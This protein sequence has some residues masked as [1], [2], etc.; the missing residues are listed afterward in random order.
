MVT[1]KYL[2]DTD[3]IVFYLRGREPYVSTLK[4]LQKEGLAVSVISVAELYEGVFRGQNPQTRE[5]GL[6]RFLAGVVV[7]DVNK[8]VA[9]VF[10]QLRAE[11]RQQGLTVADLDLLIGSTA[12]HYGLLL[13]TDN[14]RHYEKIPGLRLAEPVS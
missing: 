3:W 7:V 9:R 8:D 4:R 2:I 5:E 14:R 10:G 12:I 1:A 6:A 13:L 11:L